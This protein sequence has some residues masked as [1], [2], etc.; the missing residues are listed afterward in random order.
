MSGRCHERGRHAAPY[1]RARR[2]RRRRAGSARAGDGRDPPD[3]LPLVPHGA[4]GLDG[5]GRG[6][7][8]AGR[9]AAELR[10]GGSRGADPGG[11]R[12]AGPV[13]PQAGHP[14]RRAVAARGA[15]TGASVGVAGLDA[16]D[17]VR[18][19]GGRGRR[20]RRGRN[21]AVA[22][23]AAGRDRRRRRGVRAAARS[24]VRGAG[25]HGDVA[26]T[27]AAGPGD[28]DLRL[29]P[30]AGRGGVGGPAAG[31]P[32][33]RPG[34]SG[35]RVAG[36]DDAAVGAEPGAGDVDRPERVDGGGHRAVA[37][38]GG[39]G[40]RPGVGG[41]V[42]GRQ[43]AGDLGHQPGDRR[44]D[45][46][47]AGG[48]RGAQPPPRPAAGRVVPPGR[49]VSR[50]VNRRPLGRYL[51]GMRP[52]SLWRHEVRRAGWAALLAPL[53]AAVGLAV[54]AV[55]GAIRL[56]QPDQSTALVL[57]S[58][59]QLALPTAYRST[60]LRR[61]LVTAGWVAL[62]ALTTAAFMVASGW[63]HRW[64]EAHP[65]LAGQLTWLAPTLCLTGL[66]LLAGALSGSPA[67]A[68]IVV[69]SLWVFE[70]AAVGQLQEHRWSRR[71]TLL[72]AG[73]AMTAAGWLLL[74][75][76]SRLLT[77]EAE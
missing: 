60:I 27:G 5:R 61:L 56:D 65:A 31:C 67:V 45:A 16:G 13:G 15:A 32:A 76:P 43:D 7:R 57:Q 51:P 25:D 41:R 2:V 33:G 37:V 70:Y 23:R 66:G 72:A 20:P 39:D 10:A 11:A 49:V 3:R 53:I 74:R 35:R 24:G 55:D 34:R 12:S 48:G 6:D 47:A 28:P 9:C 77:K 18:R 46:R 64:P 69:A 59:L 63:W 38:A 44:G 26:A 54:L 14:V 62:V 36:T 30:G 8:G 71:L 50:P 22:G 42:A 19:G 75:R 29:R 58:L 40:E 73:V 68:S 1:R 21:R 17:G 4:A 52:L